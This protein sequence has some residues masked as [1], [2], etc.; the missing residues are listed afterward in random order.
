MHFLRVFTNQYIPALN[1]PNAQDIIIVINDDDTY[2]DKTTRFSLSK[3]FG[4]N[5]N[6][7]ELNFSFEVII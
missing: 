2:R 6:N 5:S 7:D 1:S 4:R 3:I